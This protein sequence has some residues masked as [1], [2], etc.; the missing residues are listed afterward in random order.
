M[1]GFLCFGKMITPVIVQVLFWLAVLFSIIVAIYNFA[2][3]KYLYGVEIIIFG[4]L[5]ARVAAELILIFFRMNDS[6][7]KIKIGL[8]D[9]KGE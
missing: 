8:T 5:L 7:N 1:K 4:P 3:A 6:L 9:G 2:H